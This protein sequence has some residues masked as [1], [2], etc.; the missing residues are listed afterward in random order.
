MHQ[1]MIGGV[2]RSKE[3]LGHFYA[4]EGLHIQPGVLNPS[5]ALGDTLNTH[6]PGYHSLI[7]LDLENL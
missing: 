5:G 3:N 2:A 1:V 6:M 4:P 7:L